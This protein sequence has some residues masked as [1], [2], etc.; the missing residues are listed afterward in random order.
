M[1]VA[2]TCQTLHRCVVLDTLLYCVMSQNA[3]RTLRTSYRSPPTP[4]P[5]LPTPPQMLLPIGSSYDN[6]LIKASEDRNSLFG[7]LWS[8]GAG[9]TTPFPLHM[10]VWSIC[11]EPKAR[12][13]VL[14][15]SSCAA[16]RET[17]QEA[18]RD[19]EG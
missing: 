18:T 9:G 6:Y 11:L 10:S 3:Q 16:R 8:W 1:P 4:Y 19:V 5:L 7:S 17:W 13:L 14:G 2:A 15:K 12:E